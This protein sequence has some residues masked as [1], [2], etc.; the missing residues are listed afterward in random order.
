M[1][2][3][4]V[5][6]GEQFVSND[7][8][9]ITYT[10]D[11]G[12][13]TNGL[14]LVFVGTIDT[15][16][17]THH[18]PTWNGV[19]MD[20]ASTYIKET[21]T[22]IFQR[23]SLFYLVNPTNGSQTFSVGHE[24][25]ATDIAT[26]SYC[27]AAWFDGAL[28]TQATVLDDSESGEGSTDPSLTLT[29]TQNG[30]L[31][32]AFYAS[33]ADAILTPGQ[34][35][36]QTVDNGTRTMG[37][38]YLI[39]TVGGSQAMTW[40]GTD[41]NWIMVAASFKA[42][43]ATA[44]PPTVDL[45]TADESTLS[46]LPT[47]AFTGTSSGADPIRYQVQISTA[48]DFDDAAFLGDSVDYL[49]SP[50]GG[51]HPNGM[52]ELTWDGEWQVDDRF[53]QSFVATGGVLD[54]IVVPVG[55][56]EVDVDGIAVVLVYAHAGTY[57]T[58][59]TPLNPAAPEDTPTPDWLAESD[60]I[61]IVYP[62]GPTGWLEFA[63]T[64]ANRIYLEPGQH[65]V[66]ILDWRPTAGIYTNTIE[67]SADVTPT[68]AGNAYVDGRSEANN[69]VRTDFDVLF[70]VLEQPHQI[71]VVSGTDSG[72]TGSPD[73]TDPFASAQQVTF[74]VQSGDTLYSGLTYYWR[75]RGIDPAGTDTYGDWSA[76]REFTVVDSLDQSVG[77]TLASAGVVAKGTSK[78]FAGTVT[79]AGAL[80]KAVAKTF[81]G[82][83]SSGG[84]LLRSI[85]KVVSG[86]L[87]SGGTVARGVTKMLV[88][89]LTT[90]GALITS[91][92][93]LVTLAGAL[94]S[95]GVLVRRTNKFVAGALT[96]GGAINRAT[97]KAIAGTLAFVGA[98]LASI[99]GGSAAHLDVTLTDSAVY[100]VTLVDS[101]V[102]NVTL[103]DA[104]RS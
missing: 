75:V 41:S 24:E 46:S 33:E 87:T 18:T 23:V 79:T 51:L 31:L 13:R 83:L 7:A 72:F 39:Q 57:G 59:S 1:P 102:N 47:L 36:I 40:T 20:V 81:G 67:L 14:L 21:A 92:T 66:W 10:V 88:G 68:H 74:T 35:A 12:T 16:T 101:A 91:L 104:S 49:G 45:D 103:G 32:V 34:T 54:R 97:G 78:F 42:V 95:S 48:A 73:S 63:F 6:S 69:G 25:G 77:G 84:A 60:P 5:S 89:T 61:A 56:D 64:G 11:I 94:T 9:P 96:T 52:A 27:I 71:D 99:V 38:S 58:S 82:T 50:T 26:G 65:Y 43:D 76:V 93:F 28:Q 4:Y 100:D 22:G 98:L 2:I 15:V 70:G 80:L 62:T 30:E 85:S 90:G 37:A 44:D 53:G 8:T 3:T 86:T 19:A 29:P 17:H 55:M